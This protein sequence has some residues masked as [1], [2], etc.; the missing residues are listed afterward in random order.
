MVAERCFSILLDISHPT[1]DSGRLLESQAVCSLYHIIKQMKI[2]PEQFQWEVSI[3][4]VTD[5]E[6]RSINKKFRNIDKSTDVLSFPLMESDEIDA[7]PDTIVY[8]GLPLMTLGDILI[9]YDTTVSQAADRKIPAGE[10]LLELL[11]H[12]LLHLM[13]FDHE[14]EDDRNKMETM[15]EDIFNKCMNNSA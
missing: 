3:G 10:R 13:G 8:V 9:S 11:I 15:E 4:I 7:I 12:G 5:D 6:I 14:N 2:D 1:F